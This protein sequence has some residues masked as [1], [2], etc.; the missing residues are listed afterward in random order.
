MTRTDIINRVLQETPGGRYLEVGIYDPARNFDLIQCEDKTGVDPRN[1]RDSEIFKTTSDEFFA[2]LDK[3]DKWNVIFLDGDH[4]Y[5]QCKT[6]VT[7]A[8]RHIEQGGYII[9]HDCL[10]QHADAVVPEKPGGGGAWNGQVWKAWRYV[11][12]RKDLL[13]FVVD[14]D[15]GVG[16]L[17]RGRRKWAVE[18]AAPNTWRNA[19]GWAGSVSADA[20]GRCNGLADLFCD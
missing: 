1:E 14:T 10:P 13:S 4:R 9:M 19:G 3:T 6:D 16:V 11:R 15:W 2:S 8:L 5:P 18:D 7:N 17:A 20:F 12:S